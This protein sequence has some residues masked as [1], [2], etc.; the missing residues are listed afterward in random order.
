METDLSGGKRRESVRAREKTGRNSESKTEDLRH[1]AG[2]VWRLCH[3]NQNKTSLLN[4]FK[5]IN[6]YEFLKVAF[7]CK[8]GLLNQTW[9]CYT[10]YVRYIWKGLK[11]IKA[12]L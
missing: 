11:P 7:I 6:L 12:C 5:Y 2:E 4:Y 10:F 1:A 3:S 9:M 8:S